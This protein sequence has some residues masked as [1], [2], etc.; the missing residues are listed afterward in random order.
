MYW[1]FAENTDNQG[2]I[3]LAK[4]LESHARSKNIDIQLHFIRQH[5]DNGTIDL[6]YCATDDM[7]ADVH[8]K[9]LAHESTRSRK[10]YSVQWKQ[11]K[12]LLR[13]S[14]DC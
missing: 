11:D 14:G 1:I 13:T 5:V 12:I 7:V 6:R 9:P 3:A 8:T 4:N 10:Q 2:A